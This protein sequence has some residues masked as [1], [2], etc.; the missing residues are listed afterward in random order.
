MLYEPD[1]NFLMKSCLSF[2]LFLSL[3]CDFVSADTAEGTYTILILPLTLLQLRC[4]FLSFTQF[5][6]FQGLARMG[7]TTGTPLLNHQQRSRQQVMDPT[8]NP[9][10]LFLVL[11]AGRERETSATFGATIRQTGLMLRRLA[12][13]KEVTWPLSKTEKSTNTWWVNGPLCGLEE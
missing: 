6:I 12:R 11:L 3:F 7:Q 10:V 1:I 5:K 4:W 9:P 2:T 8:V 13:E